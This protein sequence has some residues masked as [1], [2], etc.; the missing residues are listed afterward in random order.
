MSLTRILTSAG[1]LLSAAWLTACQ[2]TSNR[3]L[4]PIPSGTLALMAER[5]MS[6]SDPI[7]IRAYKKEAEMEIWKRASDGGYAL[8][9][10]YPV[11]R[12][13]GQ[14]G[15]KIQEGDRQTVEGFYTIKP[16]QMNPNSAY[17]L[18]F[19]TGF[20]NDFDHA[21]GRTGSYLMVHG[22][23]SSMGCFAMTDETISELYALAREAFASGQKGFQFQAY[24]FRMTAQNFAKFRND[25]NMPFWKNLKEGSDYFDVTGEEPRVGVCGKRYTFGGAEVATN[26][27]APAISL[28]VAAKQATDDRR[29]MELASKGVLP[30]RLIYKDGGQN[31]VFRQAPVADAEVDDA[32]RSYSAKEYKYR[33]LGSVSRSEALVGYPQEVSVLSPSPAKNGIDLGR[34]SQAGTIRKGW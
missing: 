24:P 19:N 28:A 4:D 8:L 22:T 17:Y 6:P 7:L 16:G 11:C 26:A 29:T 15:P 10:T 21:N 14:L 13:S 33:E 34:E 18:S 20:P 32:S 1:L 23:C 25:P 31:S 3:S 9:K 30:I 5:G 27:C 2:E 12:W